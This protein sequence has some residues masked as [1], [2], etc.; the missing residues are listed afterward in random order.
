MLCVTMKIARV[1]IFRYRTIVL[2]NYD[3]ATPGS[4]GLLPVI[5]GSQ[6]IV[7]PSANIAGV[8]CGT[9]NSGCPEGNG[10]IPGN[11]LNPTY[12]W[13]DDLTWI[14]GRHSFKTG[15]V[16]RYISFA[17][18]RGRVGDR[19]GLGIVRDRHARRQRDQFSDRPD[20]DSRNRPKR[21]CRPKPSL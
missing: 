2:A 20:R 3:P 6:V 13:G 14:K 8:G 19:R 18:H 7:N 16:L 5:D 10:G 4:S 12:Q 15:F 9:A 11:Y 21:H 1:G 17:G